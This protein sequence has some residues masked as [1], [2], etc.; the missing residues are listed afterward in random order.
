MF[1]EV[2]IMEAKMDAGMP[3]SGALPAIAPS[4]KLPTLLLHCCCGPCSSSVLEVSS[5]FYEIAAFFYNPNIMPKEEHD[6]RAESFRKLLSQAQYP[7]RVDLIE[8]GYSPADFENACS[9][10]WDQL[11][12]AKRCTACFELRLGKAAMCCAS[13]GYS[14]FTTTLSVSPHKDAALLGE[15]GRRVALKHGVSYLHLDAK[16]R[17]GFARSVEL[18][19][20]YGLYRQSYCGCK[21]ELVAR[22]QNW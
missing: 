5:P 7:N 20:Q 2:P 11:E 8:H 18:S 22:R 12:G 13:L 6:K 9:P 1:F 4:G 17:G 3:Q 14:C 10:F 21:A 16:K 19:K 15:V